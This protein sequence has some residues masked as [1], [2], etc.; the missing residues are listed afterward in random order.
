[1]NDANLEKEQAAASGLRSLL[2]IGLTEW[3]PDRA[4]VGMDIA[5]HHLNRSGLLHGGILA[6]LLD[7]AMGYA[8]CFATE[9]GLTR[10]TLTL[11]LT[12]NFIASV[13]N[14]R[15]Q[16]T[17]RRTGGGKT[18]YFADGEVCDADDRL[19]ATGAG[20]FKYLPDMPK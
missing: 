12:T 5:P 1:M 13:R 14:G 10:R 2:G 19:I 4:T 3:A 9:P 17:A 7:T 16:I 18:I 15:L 20:T 8:G 11:S 6:T